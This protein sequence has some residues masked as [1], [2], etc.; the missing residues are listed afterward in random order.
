MLI[1]RDHN[2]I[3]AMLIRILYTYRFHSHSY[4]ISNRMYLRSF[5]NSPCSQ[6]RKNPQ[7]YDL[8]THRAIISNIDLYIQT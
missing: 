1:K 7:S 3:L 2:R 4:I 5:I 8:R 6:I